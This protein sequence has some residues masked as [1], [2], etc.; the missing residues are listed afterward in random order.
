MCY[1]W[2]KR[3]LISAFC[4]VLSCN[5]GLSSS[6]LSLIPI[7]VRF[8]ISSF[9]LLI[10]LSRAE[11]C[12]LRCCELQFWAELQYWRISGTF[13]ACTLRSMP[14][15]ASSKAVSLSLAS[16]FHCSSCFRCC[17][18]ILSQCVLQPVAIAICPNSQ[19]QI[20]RREWQQSGLA[21]AG[22]QAHR[23]AAVHRAVGQGRFD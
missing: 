7:A 21:S 6:S 23:A 10:L 12:I 16:R 4:A 20:A 2:C 5:S 19:S 13:R 11:L 14:C 8:D 1:F 9:F 17:L 18:L 3:E 15:G 22:G